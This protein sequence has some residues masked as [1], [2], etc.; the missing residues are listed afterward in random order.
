MYTND[1]IHGVCF[2]TLSI[3]FN[4]MAIIQILPVPASAAKPTYDDMASLFWKHVLC[5]SEGIPAVHVV[6]DKYLAKS[7][8]TQTC[9]KRGE[10]MSRHT[11][12][13]IQ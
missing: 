6:F 10:D 12:V 4:E 8:K 13:H 11:S 7:L 5:V 2:P 1:S 3:V 9:K